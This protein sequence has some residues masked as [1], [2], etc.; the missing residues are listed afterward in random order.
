MYIETH[1]A[2]VIPL[3]NWNI[4]KLSS[5]HAKKVPLL[6]SNYCVSLKDLLS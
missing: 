3:E 5:L 2:K 1:N 6:I 4:R